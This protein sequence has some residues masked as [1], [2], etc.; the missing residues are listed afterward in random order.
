MFAAL[1]VGGVAAAMP[2]TAAE[3]PLT[4]GDLSAD[5]SHPGVPVPT[6]VDIAVSPDEDEV[7][8][9]GYI[10]DR[11]MEDADGRMD[12]LPG[13]AARHDGTDW[14]NGIRPH[15]TRS[16][17]G[18]TSDDA[19]AL[20]RGDE[21]VVGSAFTATGG[22]HFLFTSYGRVLPFGDAAFHGDLESLSIEPD[23]PVVGAATTPS[24]DGY[25]LFA[26]DGG[27]FAFGDAPFHGS[28]PEVL[29]PIGATLAAPIVGMAAT[30][31]GSGYSMVGADG[32]MFAF[33]SAPFLGSLPGMNVTPAEPVVDMIASPGGYLQLGAD[34]GTFAFG[35]AGFEGSIPFLASCG[36]LSYWP[37]VGEIWLSGFDFV[38][39][40]VLATND[41]YL[42]TD[43]HGHTYRFGRGTQIPTN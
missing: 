11:H 2:V 42:I 26:E 17:D 22:G 31:D 1:A 23:L 36:R 37:G 16:N 27:L 25:W 9:V 12:T 5:M 21:R 7:L 6:V 28:V 33:G 3:A 30:P 15:L 43:D 20:R 13:P 14:W 32:G 34:G 18:D 39:A 4:C 19:D 8:W 40:D 24:G 10:G 35:A 38:S 29:G 41:G